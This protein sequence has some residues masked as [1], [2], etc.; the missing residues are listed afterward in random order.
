[1]T[2][3]KGKACHVDDRLKEVVL[4]NKKTLT[5][6]LSKSHDNVKLKSDVECT[7]DCFFSSILSMRGEK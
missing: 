6:N 5:D 4:M 1:M 2:T 7:M 3:K